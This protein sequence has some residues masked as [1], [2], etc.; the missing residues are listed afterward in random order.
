MMYFLGKTDVERTR[1]G[2]HQ[3]SA[4]TCS[5]DSSAE[6]V[7]TLPNLRNATLAFRTEEVEDD[8]NKSTLRFGLLARCAIRQ[9]Q[10]P[11]F[12]WSSVS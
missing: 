9:T 1:G 5:S 7:R 3:I 6:T 11:P 12:I 4:R 10:L 8:S 2:C